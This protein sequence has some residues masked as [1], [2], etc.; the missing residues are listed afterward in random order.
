MDH[1]LRFPVDFGAKY[2]KENH[3]YYLQEFAPALRLHLNFVFH[4]VDRFI[5]LFEVGYLQNQIR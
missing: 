2:L 4:P 3:N 1:L 5:M